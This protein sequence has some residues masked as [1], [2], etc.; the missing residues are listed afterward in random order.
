MLHYCTGL[1]ATINKSTLSS[2]KILGEMSM[3][4]KEENLMIYP[5]PGSAVTNF[6]LTTPEQGKVLISLVDMSGKELLKTEDVL[7][8]ADT[9]TGKIA[10][11][12]LTPGVYVLK[13][14]LPSGK[15]ITKK[16][17]KN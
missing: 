1:D 7:N 6:N 8:G 16:I 14:L 17:I 9:L 11:H 3:L 15:R 13:I 2:E 4:K 10:I 5:N 12:A